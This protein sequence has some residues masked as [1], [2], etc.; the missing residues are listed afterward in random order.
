MIIVTVRDQSSDASNRMVDVLGKFIA[1]RLADFVIA[2]AI[3]DISRGKTAKI[4]NGFEV[5]DDDAV[6]LTGWHR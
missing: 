5:S 3:K 1:H 2:F 4:R 6:R